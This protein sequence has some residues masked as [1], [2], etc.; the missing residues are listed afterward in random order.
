MPRFRIGE[1]VELN[2]ILAKLHGGAIGT[3]VSVV[4]HKDGVTAL[5][6]YK[7]EFEDSR[8]RRLWSFQLTPSGIDQRCV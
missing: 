3:V 6:E 8:Q 4:P 2:G 7:I 5:D 1:F